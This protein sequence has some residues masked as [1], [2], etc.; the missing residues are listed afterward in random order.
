M[1]QE[2]AQI[3][4]NMREV[5]V[6]WC[7]RFIALLLNEKKK[8][9]GN[10]FFEATCVRSTGRKYANKFRVWSLH[11]SMGSVPFSKPVYFLTEQFWNNR[12]IKFYHLTTK[13][14]FWAGLCVNYQLIPPYCPYWEDRKLRD[15]A[16]LWTNMEASERWISRWMTSHHAITWVL[17]SP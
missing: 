13:V 7:N 3:R 8:T 1:C 16:P 10:Y 4:N 6:K 5:Q 17:I 2:S 14:S 12:S 11:T 15:S 9:V